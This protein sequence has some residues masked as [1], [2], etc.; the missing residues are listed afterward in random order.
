MIALN[1]WN[2]L[3][4]LECSNRCGSDLET[5]ALARVLRGGVRVVVG[6]ALAGCRMEPHKNLIHGRYFK[7]GRYL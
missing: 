2:L 4:C 1:L 5:L 6:P 3:S 7:D